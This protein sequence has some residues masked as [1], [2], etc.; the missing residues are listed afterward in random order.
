MQKITRMVGRTEAGRPSGESHPMA[1][2]SDRDVDL[3]RQLHEEGLG[4]RAIARKFEL[5]RYTVR[6]IVKCNRRYATAVR[7]EPETQAA[8]FVPRFD[9]VEIRRKYAIRRENAVQELAAEYRVNRDRIARLVT[10][11]E[12]GVRWADRALGG[13]HDDAKKG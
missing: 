9:E 2:I 12:L 7:F 11:M 13:G 10:G 4:Y 1:K 8:A 3:I 5:S 6:D